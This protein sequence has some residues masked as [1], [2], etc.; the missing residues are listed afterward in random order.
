MTEETNNRIDEFDADW[1]N[2][3]LCADESCIGVI[4]PDG[5]C[6]ECGK[7]DTDAPVAGE[8][9]EAVAETAVDTADESLMED[10]S[11]MDDDQAA[12]DEPVEDADWENRKLCVDESCI[13]VIGPDGRCKECG[14]KFSDTVSSE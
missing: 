14:T 12:E 2:R 6:K 1:E 11:A 8:Q 9:H 5:C 10:D 7:R 13:G 3:R 4:G